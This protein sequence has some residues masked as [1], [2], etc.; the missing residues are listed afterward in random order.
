[1]STIQRANKINIAGTLIFGETATGRS[2]AAAQ[3]TKGHTLW[4]VYNN[5]NNIPEEQ[6][7]TIPVNWQEFNEIYVKLLKGDLAYETIVIDG[8]QTMAMHYLMSLVPEGKDSPSQP[9]WGLMGGAMQELVN[10]LR[11]RSNLVVITEIAPDEE[12]VMGFTFNPHLYRKIVTLFNEKWYT[13][14]D[15]ELSREAGKAV[16]GVQKNSAAALRFK[17]VN[18]KEKA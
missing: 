13:Y 16:Y 3:I 14:I 4:V 18:N 1:M 5:T 6:D 15:P 2:M 10:R 17:P 11:L 7:V 12:G 8:F 9:Q